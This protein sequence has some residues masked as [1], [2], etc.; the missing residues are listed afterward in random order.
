MG[1]QGGTVLASLN[2]ELQIDQV[3]T[4]MTIIVGSCQTDMLITLLAASAM[5][6]HACT[7]CIKAAGTSMQY[8]SVT[9]DA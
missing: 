8:C 4:L 6:M 3:C 5:V 9:A 1:L 7:A 2:G